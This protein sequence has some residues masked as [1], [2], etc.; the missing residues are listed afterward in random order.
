MSPQPRSPRRGKRQQLNLRITGF[1][2]V[3]AGLLLPGDLDRIT[4]PRGAAAREAFERDLALD[5]ADELERDFH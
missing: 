2:K 1:G 4:A 3:D 5:E